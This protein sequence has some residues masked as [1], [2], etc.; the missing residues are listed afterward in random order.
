MI[1]VIDKDHIE[2]TTTKVDNFTREEL[3]AKKKKYEKDLARSQA[4][5]IDPIVA[6][7]EKIDDYLTQIDTFKG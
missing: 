7:L 2:I 6:G 4:M 5:F 1:K 3:L